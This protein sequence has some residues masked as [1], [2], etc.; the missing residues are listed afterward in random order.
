MTPQEMK[1][2]ETAMAYVLPWGVYRGKTLDDVKSSYLRTLAMSC[3][4]SNASNL[5]DALWNWRE[6]MDEHVY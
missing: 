4:D 2:V 5:A 3:H 6:Q 1:V